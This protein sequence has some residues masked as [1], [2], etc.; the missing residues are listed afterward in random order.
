MT[1]VAGL[2][3]G[4][5][6]VTG[7]VQEDGRSLAE[8]TVA[9]S[10]DLAE[11]AAACRNAL[12]QAVARAGRPGD[13][14]LAVTATSMH[15]GF[16]LLDAAG[17]P[18]GPGELAGPVLPALLELRAQEPERWLRTARVLFVHDWLVWL[19]SGVQVTEISYACAAGMADVAARRW[20][21]GRLDECG[22]G[23]SRL[24]PVV[25]PGTVVGELQPGWALPPTLP[26]VSG[27]G[28]LQLAA[29]GAG[30]LTDGV[31]VIVAGSTTQVLAAVARPGPA[32]A[33]L[34]LST[35]AAPRLWAL[36]GDAGPADGFAVRRDLAD[37]ERTLG[38]P[39]G[40]VVVTGS[41]AADGALPALLAQVLGRD[42]RHAAGCGGPAAGE[43]LASRALG[44]HAHAP[45][46]P[47][48]VV[49]AG[50]PQPWQEPYDRWC[51]ARA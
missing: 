20:S 22:I 27:C 11:G 33:R 29:A 39:A 14:Y 43:L 44:V 46:L 30:G 23:R 1:L 17:A 34:R 26:V 49:P 48:R 6:S 25:E 3:V 32:P 47:S 41:A 4:A 13:D 10:W 37:L 45:G 9:M 12:A 18:L 7:W 24:A 50:D 21:T 36:A 42:V 5:S 19:L 35:H 15:E 16:V 51:A 31:V 2:A 40:S 28:D 8:V 38:R